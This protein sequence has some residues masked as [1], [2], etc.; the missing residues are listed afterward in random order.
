MQNNKFNSKINKCI[1]N[2]RF[3][4]LDFNKSADDLIPNVLDIFACDLCKCKFTTYQTYNKHV[5]INIHDRIN[6]LKSLLVTQCNLIR[7]AEKNISNEHNNLEQ[8]RNFESEINDKLPILEINKES[9]KRIKKSI[10][11]ITKLIEKHDKKG[12]YNDVFN[13]LKQQLKLDQSNQKKL[14]N[15]KLII[16]ND[17]RNLKSKI[18]SLNKSMN[19]YKSEHVKLIKRRDELDAEIKGAYKVRGQVPRLK[20]KLANIKKLIT[21]YLVDREKID[22]HLKQ[23]HIKKMTEIKPKKVSAVKPKKVTAVKPKKVSEIKP[24]KIT[25]IKP[26]K[27]TEIKPK[28]VTE[29][30]P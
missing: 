13:R 30:K 1:K 4:T 20:I 11:A 14:S 18:K 7:G 16:E 10:T 25:E 6:Y 26:K 5:K 2:N 8:V 3:T 22:T 21:E 12:L 17:I 24:K 28:K 19:L 23:T 27:I 29:I 9:L 15:A